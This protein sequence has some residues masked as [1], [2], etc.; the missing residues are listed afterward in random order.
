MSQRKYRTVQ[1]DTW[2]M[3]A[4]RLWPS[5]GGEKRMS[6]LIEANPEYA[7]YVKFPAGIVLKVPELTE[8]TA[9]SIPP[10]RR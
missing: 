9:Q 4:F 10:W 2:D 7:D 5:K 8:Q 6:E 3:I 1:G